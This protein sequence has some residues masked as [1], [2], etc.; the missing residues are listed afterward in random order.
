[1]LNNKLIIFLFGLLLTISVMGARSNLI[2]SLKKTKRQWGGDNGGIWPKN[3]PI[4][5]WGQHQIPWP[6]YN[7]Q[8][9]NS[10]TGLYDYRYG[11]GWLPS[12]FY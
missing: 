11:Y 4:R 3:N 6:I 9:Q 1:M 8:A 12:A 10:Y 7:Q 2:E 5:Q